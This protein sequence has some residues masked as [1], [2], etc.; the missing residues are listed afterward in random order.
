MASPG[1]SFVGSAGSH[2][3]SDN[4]AVVVSVFQFYSYRSG[5]AEGDEDGVELQGAPHQTPRLL[6]SQLLLSLDVHLAYLDEEHR[7]DMTALIREFPCLFSD[8]PTL[9]TVLKHNIDVGGAAP[10]LDSIH[11]VLTL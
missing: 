2:V 3:K 5:P 6:N 10:R 1:D 7:A 11:T 4:P 8:V 9:T